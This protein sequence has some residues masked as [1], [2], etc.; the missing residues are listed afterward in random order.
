MKR[1]LSDGTKP[2]R[3]A[4]GDMTSVDLRFLLAHDKSGQDVDRYVDF[5]IPSDRDAEGEEG[6]Q[7]HK[8]GKHGQGKPMLSYR[9]KLWR[10]AGDHNTLSFSTTDPELRNL[11]VQTI[12][13]VY[14]TYI[15]YKIL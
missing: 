14:M 15:V 1:Q 11:K 13:L 7:T 9:E 8:G 12:L 5:S 3:R 10:R 6:K 4:T 2:S